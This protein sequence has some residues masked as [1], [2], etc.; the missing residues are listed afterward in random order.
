[1]ETETIQYPLA[2]NASRRHS[3]YARTW[4]VAVLDSI[5]I[6]SFDSLH[7]GLPSI[8]YQETMPMLAASDYGRLLREKR[9]PSSSIYAHPAPD[10]NV[11]A[12][13]RKMNS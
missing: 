1:M 13:R 11:L 6:I 4:P 10:R 5:A 7:H 8:Q 12:R 9:T 3:L 2:K